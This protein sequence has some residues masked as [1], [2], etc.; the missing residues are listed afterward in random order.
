MQ[1]IKFLLFSTFISLSLFATTKTQEVKLTPDVLRVQNEAKTPFINTLSLKYGYGDASTNIIND[2]GGVTNI[3]QPEDNSQAL[4]IRIVI[5]NGYLPLFKPYM[6]FTT[7]MYD[8]RTFYIP[9]VGLRHDFKLDNKFMEPYVSFGAGYTLMDRKVSPVNGGE[10]FEDSTSSISFTA[11]S[12]VDFYITDNIALDLSLRY[13]MYNLDTTIG[14]NYTLTTIQDKGTLSLMAGVVYR[15]GENNLDGDD[16]LD[17]V[18]NMTDYCPYTP[19][20]SSV[21]EF[22][23]SR[24]DDKDGVI[25]LYDECPNTIAGA[26]VDEK[27]CALDRDKDGVIALYDRCSDTLK[28]VPV[29]ECGCPPYKFDFSLSYT[30]NKYKIE[31]LLQSPTFKVVT[32]LNKH[33]N[34]DVR[35]TGYADNIGSTK[36]NNKISKKRALDAK[37]FLISKG[38]EAKRIKILSRG[39]T[40]GIVDNLTK[41]NRTKNRR[42]YVEIFATDKKIVK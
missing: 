15:F 27:G 31:S 23:C 39:K 19:A 34:Y 10:A 32:F 38:V 21:D 12:G 33:K 1:F 40:E 29:T 18:K 36:A 2:N 11:E 35:I 7:F 17:G 24:D 9:S 30:F 28:G 20:S 5:N 14:G 6:D 41:E 16:D 22:G 26:P 37:S 13:D 25:N 8:D 4:S 3:N 42:I